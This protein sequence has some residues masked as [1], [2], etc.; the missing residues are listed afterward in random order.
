MHFLPFMGLN[1]AFNGMALEPKG[2]LNRFTFARANQTDPAGN[3][4]C[5]RGKRSPLLLAGLG[6]SGRELIGS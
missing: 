2:G 4:F 3:G 5:L 6:G 1:L